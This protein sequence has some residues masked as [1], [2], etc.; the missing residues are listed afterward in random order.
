MSIHAGQAIDDNMDLFFADERLLAA[1]RSDNEDLLLEV[2]K[3]KGKFDI[4]F[5]DG[6]VFSF[7]FYDDQG[8]H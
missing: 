2:F 7:L 5:Q 6:C 1:A 4:N 3:H 8:R